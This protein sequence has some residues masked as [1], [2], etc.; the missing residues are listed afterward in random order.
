MKRLEDENSA[1]SAQQEHLTGNCT[2]IDSQRKEQQTAI[3]DLTA[4]IAD[5]KKKLLR[6]EQELIDVR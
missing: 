2:Q 6:T 1:L 5:S 3:K 4:Q